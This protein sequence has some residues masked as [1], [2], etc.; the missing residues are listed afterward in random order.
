MHLKIVWGIMAHWQTV[1]KSEKSPEPAPCRIRGPRPAGRRRS[2]AEPPQ[3]DGPDS[4]D[5][6]YSQYDE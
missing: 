4:H 3:E 2:A 1:T 5:Q 6:N